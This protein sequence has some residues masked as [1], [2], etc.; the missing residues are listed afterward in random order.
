MSHEQ[1]SQVCYL[2]INTFEDLLIARKKARLLMEISCN[3]SG[4]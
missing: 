4:F 1:E 2:S 3:D